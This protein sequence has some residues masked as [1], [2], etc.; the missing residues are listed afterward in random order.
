MHS[1]V[2]RGA[3]ML[4]VSS[5]LLATEHCYFVEGGCELEAEVSRM[6]GGFEGV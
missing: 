4:D 6:H 5:F 2:A 1:F 3:A